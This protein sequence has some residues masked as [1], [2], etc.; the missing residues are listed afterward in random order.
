MENSKTLG[1]Y[2]LCYAA[3]CGDNNAKTA[4]ESQGYEL[5]TLQS[6]YDLARTLFD[7]LPTPEIAL[8]A[9]RPPPK[10][11]QQ[12]QPKTHISAYVDADKWATLTPSERLDTMQVLT[13]IN[14]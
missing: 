14:S 12:Q 5:R 2:K 7:A 13:K 1:N 6:L 9:I 8:S 3:I 4:L 10:Q 11:Q